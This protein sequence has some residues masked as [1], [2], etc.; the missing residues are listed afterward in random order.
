M[1]VLCESLR[2]DCTMVTKLL[3]ASFLSVQYLVRIISAYFDTETE[4]GKLV[5]L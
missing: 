1:Y 3:S 2:D 4:N 5:G